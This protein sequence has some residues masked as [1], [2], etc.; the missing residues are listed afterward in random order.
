VPTAPVASADLLPG[1][2]PAASRPSPGLHDLQSAAVLT[3]GPR[4]GFG[5]AAALVVRSLDGR[6]LE[7]EPLDAALLRLADAA[8]AALR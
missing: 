3:L 5:A 8:V 2:R 7:D 6:R 1:P 4:L